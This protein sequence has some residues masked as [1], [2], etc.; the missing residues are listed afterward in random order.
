MPGATLTYD[1]RP[2]DSATPRADPATDRFAVGAAGFGTLAG[3][4][5]DRTVVTYDHVGASAAS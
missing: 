2:G 4:F 5:N 1:V 3:H